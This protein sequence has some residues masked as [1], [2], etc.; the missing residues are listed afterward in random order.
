M[1]GHV[2]L[3]LVEFTDHAL[4]LFSIFPNLP[5]IIPGS[6]TSLSH[7]MSRIPSLST[8]RSSHRDKPSIIAWAWRALHILFSVHSICFC[9]GSS[10][11][12]ASVLSLVCYLTVSRCSVLSP[13]LVSPC[14][15]CS[16]F[17]LSCIHVV[18]FF[19]FLH[20]MFPGIDTCPI[21]A[22]CYC[23]PAACVFFPCHGV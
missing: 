16:F 10:H 2:T 15:P 17:V 8:Q 13:W 18:L 12:L 21:D 4:I 1:H 20:C 6:A 11:V 5:L 7:T 22:V 9:F 19:Y 23:L 14:V 3:I